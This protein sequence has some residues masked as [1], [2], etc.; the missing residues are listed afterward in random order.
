LSFATTGQSF[1]ATVLGV[2]WYKDSAKIDVAANGDPALADTSDGSGVDAASLLPNPFSVTT[3]GT[4]TASRKV[5]D[6]VN[7]ESAAGTLVVHVDAANP[8]LGS[9]PTAG[10]F[11]LGS[12]GGTQSVGPI[13]ASDGESGVDDTASTLSGTVN[14]STVG[15][16]TVS[17]TAKDNVGHSSA[18]KQCTYNVNY[19]WDGFRQPVDNLPTL[20]TVKAGQSIPMKFSLSGN[21]GLSILQPSTTSAPN[22]KVTAITC[23]GGSTP[24][25]AIEQTTTANNGLTYDATADQYNYVWKTQSTYAGK[26]YRFDMTLIDG[27]THSALFKFSK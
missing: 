4:S 16:K 21:Q 7:N 14:T 1:K 5:K 26:C 18:T 6:N 11:I 15:E 22:P 8:T 24:M 3:N 25:D 2:D 23:P 12:G 9:C 20:N 17:F 13:T 10:P 27:T 19:N